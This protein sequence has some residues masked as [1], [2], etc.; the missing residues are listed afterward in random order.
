MLKK[1]IIILVAVSLVA[2]GAS[3]RSSLLKKADAYAILWDSSFV[4][5]GTEIVGIDLKSNLITSKMNIFD[6]IG[7]ITQKNNVLWLSAPAGMKERYGKNIYRYD[8]EKKTLLKVIETKGFAPNKIFVKDKFIFVS[9]YISDSDARPFNSSIE[10]YKID[11]IKSF[12]LSWVKTI[13]LDRAHNFQNDLVDISPSLNYIYV[14]ADDPM[15]D[16]GPQVYKINTETFEIDTKVNLVKHYGGSGGIAASKEHLYISALTK[17][18]GSP[19]TDEEIEKM[20]DNRILVLDPKTLNVIAEIKLTHYFPYKLIYNPT[21][22]QLYVLHNFRSTM[23]I[24]IVDC[25]LKK[26]VAVIEEIGRHSDMALADSNTLF[27]TS[28][29]QGKEGIIA[30]DLE[31]KKMSNFFIGNY[32][33]LSYNNNL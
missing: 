11:D 8:I 14:A 18:P 13:Y 5:S 7:E 15:L 31:T 21:R 33:A 9:M 10:V 26:E 28:E 19:G 2:F 6:K 4:S 23:A 17:Y 20:K 3:C 1:A 12:S 24:S 16:R 25:K 22:N 27:V 30:I 29:Y 32:G